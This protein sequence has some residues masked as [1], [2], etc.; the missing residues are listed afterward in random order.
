VQTTSLDT[1]GDLGYL[2]L[3]QNKH[4]QTGG[5]EFDQVYTDSTEAR[6]DT[7]GYIADGDVKGKEVAW[8]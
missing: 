1:C 8:D 6:Q 3:G 5:D 2:Q 7:K 4:K